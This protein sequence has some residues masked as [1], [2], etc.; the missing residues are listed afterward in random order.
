MKLPVLL[1]LALCAAA[2]TQPTTTTTTV[3]APPPKESNASDV[4]VK[5]GWWIVLIGVG[6]IFVGLVA[7]IVSGSREA[8][9]YSPAKKIKPQW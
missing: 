4:V 6:L 2:T 7:V 8:A 9:T 5:D 1:A 3:K